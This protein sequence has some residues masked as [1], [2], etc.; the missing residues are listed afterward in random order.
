MPETLENA[1]TGATLRVV[2]TSAFMTI[3]SWS[4]EDGEQES[5]DVA[6]SMVFRGPCTGR[7]TLRVH[8][9]LL[10]TLIQNTL[11]E[12]DENDSPEEKSR[13][14]LCEVLNMICG[15]L[16]TEWQGEEAIFNLSPP[17]IVSPETADPRPP[18][19][20]VP[21]TIEGTRA[22]VEIVI[23]CRTEETVATEETP[24]FSGENG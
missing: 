21:F 7:L 14:A 8:S 23:D 2:E 20:R 24:Q 3:W 6:A 17:E 1:I 13:D 4:E 15:N 18:D 9:S 11:G 10:P 16:L 5:P 19:I 22:I 12:L